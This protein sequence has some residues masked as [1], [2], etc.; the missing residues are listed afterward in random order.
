MPQC[1]QYNGK[2]FLE[3]LDLV[4][5]HTTITALTEAAEKESMCVGMEI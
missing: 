4:H 5:C 2:L 3:K 1:F